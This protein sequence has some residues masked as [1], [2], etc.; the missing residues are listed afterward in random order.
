VSKT[1]EQRQHAL[2][3]PLFFA[4]VAVLM[5]L[6]LTMVL[7]SSGIK[8][9]QV[10]GDP[11]HF[12][13]RQALFLGMSLGIIFFTR[14]VPIRFVFRTIYIW[15]GLVFVLLILTLSP[16]GFEAGGAQRWLRAGPFSLQPLEL[17]KV[18]LVLYF[19]YFFSTKQ[20]RV[21]TFHIGFLP[22]ALI[23]CLMVGLLILQ[24]D[25][26]GAVFLMLL[27]FLM[28]FAGG[29]RLFYLFCM[30]VFSAIT[31]CFM[32]LGS[33]YRLDRF[34]AIAHPFQNADGSAYQIVQ[35]L[36]G[37]AVGGVSGL[38]LGEG[39]QKLFFLPEAH[40]D[41]ILAVLGEELGFVGISV[42]FL[43]FGYI[44]FKML[45]FT[46][47]DT[48]DQS[49]L[50]GFGLSLVLIVGFFLHTAVVL[51]VIPPKGLALPF[52][53]YGGSSLLC[54]SVCVG[55]LLSMTRQKRKTS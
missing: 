15:L 6:G 47:K 12:F 34:L 53:S 8:A 45:V 55:L 19:A 29:V 21:T 43:C 5:G 33:S 32:V 20:D 23:T 39:R 52:L 14:H 48:D 9:E 10:F 38:G 42:V 24:P 40:T 44:L 3:D 30:F 18:V 37:L 11:Y 25:F 41:F 13:K 4:A 46:V 27:F 54:S 7:S 49:R 36:Y 16:L 28:A 35:S 31:G 26:G 17:A 22:P 51:G 50:A 1:H 2:F